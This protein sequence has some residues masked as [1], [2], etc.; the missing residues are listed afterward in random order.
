MRQCNQFR[1]NIENGDRSLSRL[2][3]VLFWAKVNVEAAAVANDGDAQVAR[4]IITPVGK[5]KR[6][7]REAGFKFLTQKV[8]IMDDGADLNRLTRITGVLAAQAVP[9]A[10]SY[11]GAGS[12]VVVEVADVKRASELVRKAGG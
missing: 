9:V 4:M 12:M 6:A 10:F 1:V 11:T 2:L 3:R 7:L 5:T 8:L